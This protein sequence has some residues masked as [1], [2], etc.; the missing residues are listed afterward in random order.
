MHAGLG[1]LADLGEYHSPVLRALDVAEE[2]YRRI[3]LTLDMD[4]GYAAANNQMS[5]DSDV[6][7]L[8]DRLRRYDLGFGYSFRRLGTRSF[9]AS[10]AAVPARRLR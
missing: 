5:A 2:E 9:A 10:S 1:R 7:R 3:D 8:L 4:F 6:D